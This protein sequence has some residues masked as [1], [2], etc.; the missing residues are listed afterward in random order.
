LRL[1]LHWGVSGACWLL[2]DY[3]YSGILVGCLLWLPAASDALSSTGTGGET[4]IRYRDANATAV[5]HDGH[6]LKNW[7]QHKDAWFGCMDLPPDQ[8]GFQVW[9]REGLLGNASCA[10]LHTKCHGWANSSK[11]MES[12]PISCFI[13]DPHVKKVKQGPPCYDSV[14]TGVRFKNGPQASCLDLALYCNHSTLYYHVQAACRKT[15]GLCDAHVGHVEGECHDL[16]PHQEPEF[17]VAGALAPCGD[18][19]DFCAGNG[20][21]YLI[22]HKCPKTC[23]AC[24]EAITSTHSSYT[25][26]QEMTF[27]SG[28]EPSDCDR[29]RRWGF[30]S[31]RRRRNL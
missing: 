7:T 22:R 11:V 10:D 20:E 9:T 5:P 14:I 25:T 3:M 18:L 26:S 31:T 1:S 12:C 28:Q 13:C 2:K 24:P 30:C 27:N 17:M 21:A 16:E 8:T 23:G 4:F 15:C 6:Q 29:R 19:M